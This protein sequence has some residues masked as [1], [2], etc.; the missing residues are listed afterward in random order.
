M[1]RSPEQTFADWRGQAQVLRHVGQARSY[2]GRYAGHVKGAEARRRDWIQVLKDA[3]ELPDMVLIE[4]VGE[5]RL[6]NPRELY[7]TLYYQAKGQADLNQW[8]NP[9]QPGSR[10]IGWPAEVRGY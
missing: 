10:G 4:R 1:K 6:L 2:L 9:G 8:V 7:W 5:A 3:G